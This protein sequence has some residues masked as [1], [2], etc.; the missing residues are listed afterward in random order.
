MDFSG[1][2]LDELE[3][4]MANHL[5]KGTYK[6]LGDV[7]F[8]K[9]FLERLKKHYYL[10]FAKSPYVVYEPIKDKESTVSPQEEEASAKIFYL[11]SATH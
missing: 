4:A 10:S 1:A 8:N 5:S 2:P 3:E 11:L 6:F 7:H 9:G